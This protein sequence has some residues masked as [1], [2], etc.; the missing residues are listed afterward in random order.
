MPAATLTPPLFAATSAYSV[1]STARQKY[2]VSLS[3][4]RTTFVSPDEWFSH[5]LVEVIDEREYLSAQIFNRCK[6]A[7]LS[8]RRTKILNHIGN[9]DPLVCGVR[10]YCLLDVG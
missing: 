4:Q 7:R 9:K 2:A 1:T 10:C 5:S 3:D 6:T 8:N